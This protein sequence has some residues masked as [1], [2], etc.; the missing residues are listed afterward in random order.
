MSV[1]QIASQVGPSVEFAS[2]RLSAVQAINIRP[3]VFSDSKNRLNV[4]VSM[5]IEL[6]DA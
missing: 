6:G 3:L 1:L 2:A 5:Y 4:S